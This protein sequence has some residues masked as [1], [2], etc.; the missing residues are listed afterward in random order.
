VRNDRIGLDGAIADF[1]SVNQRRPQTRKVGMRDAA[2]LAGAAIV[3]GRAAVELLRQNR[4][5]ADGDGP[6]KLRL[7]TALEI[8]LAAIHRHRRLHDAVG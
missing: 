8:P 1:L 5:A 2:V 7:D 3:A 4:G 6:A